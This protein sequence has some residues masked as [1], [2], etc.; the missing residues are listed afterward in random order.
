M[1]T[2]TQ[3]QFPPFIMHDTVFDDGEY[4]G[5]HQK[6]FMDTTQLDIE[7]FRY[8]NQTFSLHPSLVPIIPMIVDSN[9]FDTKRRQKHPETNVFHPAQRVIGS[10]KCIFCCTCSGSSANAVYLPLT[11]IDSRM[12]VDPIKTACSSAC[13]REYLGSEA[14]YIHMPR[15]LLF[16]I[17]NQCELWLSEY[18]KK[19]EDLSRP[20]T[21]ADVRADTRLPPGA[22]EVLEVKI[23][24]AESMFDEVRQ[25][26][27][28]VNVTVNQS[29]VNHPEV[30]EG[31]NS[32]S[33][34]TLRRSM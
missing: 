22:G 7:T 28:D 3:I 12:I 13:A 17:M 10:K 16:E 4:P 31:D 1:S 26:M 33:G 2:R 30:I 11:L 9:S 32:C 21:L 6:D 24:G 19:T 29:A 8:R 15:L 34:K 14:K 18:V 5:T 20:W 25:K 23:Q 27:M